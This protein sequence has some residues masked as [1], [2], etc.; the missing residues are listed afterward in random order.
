MKR[1]IFLL[2]LTC[3]ICVAQCSS[4]SYGAYT[5]V[6]SSVA[7]SGGGSSSKAFTLSVT[8]GNAVIM[9]SRTLSAS[10]TLSVAGTGSCGNTVTS[11]GGSVTLANSVAI[12]VITT[13]SS[14]GTCTLTSTLTG[15]TSTIVGLMEQWSGWNGGLD[16]LGNLLATGSISSGSSVSCPAVTPNDSGDLI[17]CMMIDNGNNGST[18]TPTSPFS[19]AASGDS[20]ASEADVQATAALI[21]PAFHYGSTAS[22][23]VATITLISGTQAPTFSLAVG[24]YTSGLPQSTTVAST[25]SGAFLCVTSCSTNGCM[26]SAPAAASA[27]TCSAGTQYSVNSQA[28]T[29]PVVLAGNYITYSALATKSGSNNSPVVT[30]PQYQI[31][32]TIS[33]I[34]VTPASISVG[35]ATGD[36]NQIYAEPGGNYINPVSGYLQGI[37]GIAAPFT[38]VPVENFVD[39]N[40]GT[41]TGTPTTGTLGTSTYGSAPTYSLAGM[42]AGMTYSNTIT[43]GV[44]PHPISIGGTV[45]DNS[46]TL[47]LLCTTSSTIAATYCGK[48]SASFTGSTQS[49]SMGMWLWTNV[50]A[51]SAIDGGAD[52][53]IAGGVDYTSIHINGQGGNASYNG[54]FEETKGGNSVA[55]LPYTSGQLMRVNFLDNEGESPFTATY[56]G[57]SASIAGTNTLAANQAVMLSTTGTIPTGI[58]TNN[59]LWTGTYTSGII[60]T[61]TT[62]QLC[63]ISGFNGGSGGVAYVALTGTNAVAGGSPLGFNPAAIPSTVSLVTSYGSGYTSAPTSATA[64]SPA[65][66]ATCSGTVVVSTT[67]A[68]GIPMF[69]SST[70]LSGSTFQVAATQGAASIV[71]SGAGTGTQTITVLDLMT[72]CTC[73][74]TTPCANPTF[75]GTTFATAFTTPAAPASTWMGVNGEGPATAGYGYWWGGFAWDITGLFSTTSCRI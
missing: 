57:S 60:A 52:G 69:V 10:G 11:I 20:M 38:A 32:P 50:P 33:S 6:N 15:A 7:A 17:L 16:S 8:A 75:L 61:G 39:F 25:T 37:G 64:S 1:L 65:G 49:T 56:T 13:A 43:G 51:S 14:T 40:G 71:P 59:T 5:C 24:N 35:T 27:G 47:G 2:L 34:L 18:Y 45:Y 53:A 36:I 42:G 74:S 9:R 46:G 29:I 55:F 19:L 41:N 62:G 26:P 22:F 73:P 68:T 63:K 72:V 31:T 48:P 3:G 66:G 21:T 30:S 44:L 23:G 58:P 12:V 70:G 4:T 67:I 54:I 28:L